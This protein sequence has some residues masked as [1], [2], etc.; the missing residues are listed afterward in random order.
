MQQQGGAA[1]A[2]DR[3]VTVTT[4]DRGTEIRVRAWC[5]LVRAE[6]RQ[7]MM[8]RLLTKFLH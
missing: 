8:S 3:S 5:S 2:T 7:S 4:T 6:R 1:L